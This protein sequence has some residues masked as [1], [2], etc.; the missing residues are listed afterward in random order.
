MANFDDEFD[1]APDAAFDDEFEKAEPAPSMI[2]RIASKVSPA[3]EAGTEFAGDLGQSGVDFARGAASGLTMGGID[4]LGGLIGA[5]AEKALSF[6]PG[7]EAHRSAQIDEQLKSQGFKTPEEDLLDKYRSYQQGIE[8]TMKESRERSPGL[9]LAGEVGG[10]ITSGVALGGLFGLGKATQGA[11]TISD[12]ARD[13][14]KAKAAM[15]LLKRGGKAYATAAPLIAAESALTS[16]EQLIGPEANPMGVAADVGGGLAFGVPAIFGMQAIS[17]V[18]APKAAELAAQAKQKISDIA[19][20]SPLLRQMGIAYGKYGQELK[21]NPK[22]EKAILEGVEGVEGG[23]PFSLLDTKRAQEITQDVLNLDQQLGKHVGDSIDLSKGIRVDASDILNDTYKKIV[24]LSQEMPS[25]AQDENFAKT[26]GKIFS[27]DYTNAS[28]RDIKNAIDD[29]TNT[30]D[31]V[32]SYKYPS[33]ELEE[34]PRLLRDLRRQLDQRLKDKVPAYKEAAE[35]FSQFRSAYM[36]QPIAGR[37]DPEIDD[38]F[39]GNLKKGEK[40]L[41]ESFEDMVKR[42][43]ADAQSGENTEARFSKF[44][45]ATKQFQEQELARQAAGKIEAPITQDP[46]ELLSKIKNYADDAAVR[47]TTRKTQETQAG[48]AAAFKNILGLGD[49]GRGAA[50]STAYYAG[51][52]TQ[53]APVKGVVKVGKAIYNAPAQT[54]SNLAAKLEGTPG[55]ESFGVALRKGLE[56]GDSAKK[57]AALF[58]I[59]QNPNARLLI[60]HEDVEHENGE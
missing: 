1:K 40:K 30:I 51:R 58:T 32:D 33:P 18:A 24:N 31:R 16:E 21:V 53:L 13:E 19:E 4:E 23:T 10:G 52:A 43:T 6:I 49:T 38:I 41:T 2:D 29:I 3:I 14:G 20:D 45:Q 34:A 44:A 5:G 59:M 55:L 50:L 8:Q 26:M 46:S 48:G 28:P 54:L 36:E 39:Y 17:D 25:L 57:N 27:R 9:T 11:K 47:R 7:T 56:N 22:S 60:S 15:E 12:I 42:T 37:F 35:R